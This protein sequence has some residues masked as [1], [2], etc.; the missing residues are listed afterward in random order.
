MKEKLDKYGKKII[1]RKLY[2]INWILPKCG[3][4]INNYESDRNNIN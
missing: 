1:L 2:E 4:N 3:I